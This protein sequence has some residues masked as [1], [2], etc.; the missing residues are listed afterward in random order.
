LSRLAARTGIPV[1]ETQA[2]KGTLCFDHA[3]SAG[4]MGVTGTTTANRLARESDL[5]VGIGTRYSDF[6]TASVT[7]FQNREGELSL[8]TWQSLTSL[9]PESSQDV[10]AM[11][12]I[13]YGMQGS[14]LIAIDK[15]TFLCHIVKAVS[16]M[17]LSIP[18]LR[19]RVL[20]LGRRT[21]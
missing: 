7:A 6:T 1:A 13:P 17:A 2:G 8:S 5:I 4:A 11:G 16:K 21:T 14:A 15:A 20:R 18:Y 9:L 12:S 10:L 3:Q 19:S